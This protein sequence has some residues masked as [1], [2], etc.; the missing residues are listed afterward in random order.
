MTT[1]F[2][3]NSVTWT[4]PDLF[5]DAAELQARRAQVAL[6][7]RDPS[8]GSVAT[9]QA[10]AELLAAIEVL[11]LASEHLQQL[12]QRATLRHHFSLRE[13]VKLTGLPLATV[14]RWRLDVP[15]SPALRRA[16]SARG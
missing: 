14:Q 13:L 1:S 7:G 4:E 3:R 11:E 16:R 9:A 12:L 5:P 15:P 2:Q 10:V 8:P 6:R